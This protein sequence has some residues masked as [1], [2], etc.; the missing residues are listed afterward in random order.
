M[1]PQLNLLLLMIQILYSVGLRSIS[2]MGL[3]IRYTVIYLPHKSLPNVIENI[4][5]FAEYSNKIKIFSSN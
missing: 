4:S 5:L 2:Y 1:R 3:F